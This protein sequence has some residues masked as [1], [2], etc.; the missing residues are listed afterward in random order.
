[1]IDPLVS[2]AF[3]IESNPGIY[4]LLVGSGISRSAGIPTGWDIVIDLIKKI[5][6]LSGEDDVCKD[7][8]EKW[9]SDKFKRTPDYSELLGELVKTKEERSQLLKN[10]FEPTPEDVK[11]GVKI[12]T[13]AHIAIAE[14]VEKNY[15]KIIITTNF[16][17]LLEKALEARGITPQVISTTDSIKGAY[18]L[19]NAN[20]TIIKVN[21]DY[22][23]VR[24]RNTEKELASYETPMNEYIDEIFKQFGLIICGWSAE[25]DIA[26]REAIKRGSNYK[27]S[28]YWAT[29]KEPAGAAKD[30]IQFRKAIPITIQNADTFFITL[31][32][33]VFA[34]SEYSTTH[35]LSIKVAISTI[36]QYISE[37]KDIFLHDLVKEETERLCENLSKIK[38][39][40]IVKWDEAEYLTR[41]IQYEKMTEMLSTMI[42]TGCYWGK[43]SNA[44]IWINC[45]DK[46]SNISQPGSGSFLVPF[47]NLRLYPS[48]ILLYSGGIA[49]LARKKYDITAALLTEPIVRNHTGDET[50]VLAV[51]TTRVMERELGN[52]LPDMKGHYTPLSDH[53]FSLLKGLMREFIFDDIKYEEAFDRFELLF[54]LVH[55]DLNKKRGRSPVGPLGRFAWKR[56]L[57]GSD[58][59]VHKFE[60]ELTQNVEFWQ[61]GLFGGSI[62]RYREIN[63]DIVDFIDRVGWI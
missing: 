12:P 30:I 44:E 14:L 38:I 11:K 18:P 56:R 41:V 61:A 21:G 42:T 63:K 28:M 33:K 10:Y 16:D 25:W 47:V 6:H 17:R 13:D 35:P 9:Y 50:I 43:K 49:S 58:S 22:L 27:F 1:M 3:S 60:T 48:L 51:N 31:R 29:R 53:L 37:N 36:K 57:G 46:V 19:A 24:I 23:D 2:L 32:D 45:L 5:A 59:V 15:L 7:N 54:A 34:I 55:A 39:S 26:L 4:T 20:C 40:G 62:D 52:L 8:P